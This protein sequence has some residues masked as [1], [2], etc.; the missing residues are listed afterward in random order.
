MKNKSAI[1]N[2]F[3]G[4]FIA[5]AFSSCE[6]IIDVDL[7]TNEPK[8]VIEANVT[9]EN[10]KQ[11]VKITETVPFKADNV[12]KNLSGAVV[13]V[14]EEGGAFYTFSETKPGNYESSAA[15]AGKEGKTYVLTVEAGGKTYTS[16]SIMPKKVGLDSLSITELKVFDETAKFLK[17]HYQ[18]PEE[19][20]N[21][22][23]F[24]V[25]NNGVLYKGFFVDNDKFNNGKYVHNTVYVDE[26]K[27]E[28]GNEIEVEFQNIT[29]EIYKYFYS[30][31]QI[32]GAG[33]PP[34]AA[35]NPVSN[36]KNG[37]LGYF[38]TH[39]TQKT[40]FQVTKAKQD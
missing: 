2:I 39:T 20:G 13:S 35:S 34:V 37:A 30:L 32:T 14:Q 11:V 25:K 22:Y 23:R 3:L 12:L 29:P 18:D 19:K 15:F 40:V 7:K 4:L 26:P 33:G 36:I 6:E 38:S 9:N 31:A 27:I 10:V 1:L 21:S 28:E 16:R 5:T 8:I 24:V 17:L